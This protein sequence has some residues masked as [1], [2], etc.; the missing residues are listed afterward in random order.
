METG[1]CLRRRAGTVPPSAE[2]WLGESPELG[3]SD[4]PDGRKVA[5][6]KNRGNQI[7]SSCFQAALQ[8]K[9]EKQKPDEL[10]PAYQQTTLRQPSLF[11]LCSWNYNGPLMPVFVWGPQTGAGP[12]LH[13]TLMEPCPHSTSLMQ[14][15]THLHL[16]GKTTEVRQKQSIHS[17]ILREKKKFR[18]FRSWRWSQHPDDN[19]QI[20]TPWRQV[21][22]GHSDDNSQITTL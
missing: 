14:W 16:P 11:V 17:L 1:V 20:M 12:Q 13:F 10:Q 15:S 18:L 19:S 6:H 3:V 4:G 22:S 8:E 21:T 9:E 2:R 7:K 5:Q